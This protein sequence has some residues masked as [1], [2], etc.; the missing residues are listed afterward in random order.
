MTYSFGISAINAIMN[1]GIWI[2]APFYISPESLGQAALILAFSMVGSTLIE[3]SFST[4]IITFNIQSLR[5]ATPVLCF[6]LITLFAYTGFLFFIY[7]LKF[8]FLKF[9][10]LTLSN[11]PFILSIPFMSSFTTIYENINKGFSKFEFIAKIELGSSLI[12]FTMFLVFLQF[13]HDFVPLIVSLISK[14]LTSFILYIFFHNDKKNYA[15]KKQT[16]VTLLFWYGIY[17]L[18]EKILTVTSTYIDTFIVAQSAGYKSLGIYE[19]FKKIAVRPVIILTNA[20]ENMALPFLVNNQ[21]KAKIY[22]Y[23]YSSY[24]SLLNIL[25][26][27]FIGL[28]TVS[29]PIILK[30]LPPVYTEYRLTLYLLMTY[31]ICIVL[32][33]SIDL[34]LYSI[35]KS[36]VFFYWN[37]SYFFP[38][39]I[40]LFIVSNQGLN[41]IIIAYCIF[42][43]LLFLMA[44][45]VVFNTYH[46]ILN[47]KT[48]VKVNIRPLCI[49][50]I[51]LVGS[52]LIG[53]LLPMNDYLIWITSITVF[54]LIYTTALYFEKHMIIKVN[55]TFFSNSEFR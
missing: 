26:F 27:G 11:L 28:M 29:V 6:N 23:F 30:I 24:I 18:G 16:K 2:I 51:S 25:C 33:N 21:M 13:R 48:F 35:G 15:I 43:I 53:Q 44:E 17:I 9:D 50:L 46:D 52:L 38:L 49:L 14:Y 3:N 47:K 7:T 41:H 1:L 12:A 45:K 55:T 10:I 22:N 8:S 42:Y 20:F 39:I 4:G 54:S 31:G 32:L 40:T 19:F 34:L 36:K 5:E 37:L